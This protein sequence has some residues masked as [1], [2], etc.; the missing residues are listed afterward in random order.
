[1]AHSTMNVMCAVNRKKQL[2]MHI[3]DWLAYSSLRCMS[4]GYWKTKILN[5]YTIIY[6]DLVVGLLSQQSL[7]CSLVHK[8]HVYQLI[9]KAMLCFVSL[10]EEALNEYLKTKVVTVEY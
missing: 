4:I 8:G 1:M 10:G 2:G 3:L 9:I 7:C 6:Y 5:Q